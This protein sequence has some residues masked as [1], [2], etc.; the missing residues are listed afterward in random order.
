MIFVM[1]NLEPRT[2]GLKLTKIKHVNRE[3]MNSFLL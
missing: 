1:Q 2:V 3:T